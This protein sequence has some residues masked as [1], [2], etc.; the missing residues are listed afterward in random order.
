M[1]GFLIQRLAELGTQR[2]GIELREGGQ[3]AQGE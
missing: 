2:R 3:T 1:E